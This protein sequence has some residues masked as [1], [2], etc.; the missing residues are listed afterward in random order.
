MKKELSNKQI[1]V[2]AIIT[3]IAIVLL[4][5]L[6][7]VNRNRITSLKSGY[8]IVLIVV[9]LISS[10]IS[11]IAILKIKNE[12]FSYYSYQI[13]DFLFLVVLAVLLVQ[14]IFSFIF[15][16]AQVVQT[17]M[18]PV[19]EDGQMV[20][21]STDT[22]E[23]ERFD[24]VVMLIDKNVANM[25]GNSLV[26]GEY[27]VKRVIALP[28][29]TVYYEN[30]KLYINGQYVDEPFLKDNVITGDFTLYKD[31]PLGENQYLL[32]GD[33][34]SGTNINGVYKPGSFDGRA[35]GAID[36]DLIMGVVK[37]KRIG[38]F[39]WARVE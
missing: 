26:E 29:E 10:I 14:F 23:I 3:L 20:I 30:E 32:L 9:S 16:P 28:G 21:S 7:G 39:H 33:H 4:A 18:Y 22:D 11:I 5:V 8:I 38:F 13:N 17:S 2:K 19:L 15:F 12:V 24:I 35:F 1:I 34:R 25:S 37:Y 36:G 27:I 31:T 6:M